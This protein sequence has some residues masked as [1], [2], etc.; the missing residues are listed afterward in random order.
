MTIDLQVFPVRTFRDT[1]KGKWRKVPAIP[2]GEDWKSYKADAHAIAHAANIGVVIPDGRVVIDLDVYKGVTRKV[3]DT[4]LGVALDWE[5]A[6][7][8]RTVSGGEHYCFTLPEGAT[9]PQGSNLLGIDGFD[10]RCAG[11]G[12]ICTGEGYTDLTILG[13]P[14][15]IGDEDFP[16]LPIA[17]VERLNAG[18]VVSDGAGVS[19]LE[20]AIS[21]QPLDGLTLEQMRYYLQR[22]PPSDLE[23]YDPW[24]KVGIAIHHQTGGSN[25]GF[26]LWVDWSRGSSHFDIEECRKKWP[27]FGKREHIAKPAR[28][29]YVIYRAGG[30]NDVVEESKFSR[31]LER[32]AAVETKEQYAEFKKEITALSDITLP[33]D[34]RSM[35]AG[36]LALNFGKGEGKGLTRAEIKKAL[37][38]RKKEKRPVGS[39]PPEWCQDWVYVESSCEFANTRLNYTIKREAFNAKFDRMGECLASEATASHMA[40]NVYQIDTVVDKMFWPGAETIFEHDG[41]S[42]L[43]AYHINGVRPCDTI[44]EDGQTVVDMFVDHVRFSVADE[45]EQRILIDW[46]AYVV[47][48]P[49][50]RV[51]W[52]LLLQGAQGSGKSYFVKMLQYVLGD[53]VRNLDP[54]AIAG[55]FT[56]WAHGALV[57][58]VEEIRISGTN[59]YEVLDRMKPFITNDTVQIEEKGRDH[60]TVPNFTSYLML[61]NHKDAI[62]LTSGDRR[63]C[64]IFSRIQSEEQLYREKGGEKGAEEYFD[65]LFSETER[66]ADALARFLLD[67]KLSAEFNPRG[68]APDTKARQMMMSVATSPERLALE[69]AIAKHHCGVIN[70]DVLD[71][72][73]LNKLC[74][75][76]GEVI[77]KA[78]TLTAILLEMGYEQ[79][80]KKRVKIAKTGIYHY[81]WFKGGDSSTVIKTVREFHNDTDFFIP[82]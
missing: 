18:M 10:T 61:T 14:G 7:L 30:K 62:P 77:P 35:L 24:V 36:E 8:Q 31:L 81:V 3:V 72:T 65:R 16:E 70:D 56:G 80:E 43:N 9:V 29:D 45:R 15:A 2:K 1:Q 12:W 53:H 68:R 47:Q 6:Q 27:S 13:M 73:W 11:R 42:M 63:Y 82:F 44:D 78:R 69:D 54:T 76:E 20:Q 26:K 38:A 28:F 46:L 52:A 49:G 64:V 50:K 4:A 5:P 32:A 23:S 75:A 67:W 71:V 39:E 51:N 57:I 58:G 59:R 79:I 55:R 41:K 17:A 34:Y 37:A 21:H 48:N 40:L 19:D 33:A 66:R 60:R 22:L 25:D 74:E